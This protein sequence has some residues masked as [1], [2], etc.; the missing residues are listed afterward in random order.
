MAITPSGNESPVRT[1]QYMLQTIAKADSRIPAPPLNGEFDERTL[2]SVM[3]FQR[4]HALPVTGIVEAETW[5][6]IADR[7]F[8]AL[9]EASRPRGANLYPHSNFIFAENEYNIY[10]YP[11]QAMLVVLSQLFSNLNQESINGIL[12]HNT[13]ENTR[14]LQ[15]VAGLEENGLFDRNVWEVLTRLYD[16]FVIRNSNAAPDSPLSLARPS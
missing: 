12:D 10:L 13:M 3:T 14:E 15:K 8:L 7:F 4:E 6:R 1:L 2:E 9:F 16:T 11:I 5:N